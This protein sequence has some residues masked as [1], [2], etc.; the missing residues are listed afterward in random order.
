M[1][2]AERLWSGLW[3]NGVQLVVPGLSIGPSIDKREGIAACGEC[4][5]IHSP[6][7][8]GNSRAIYGISGEIS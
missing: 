6:G 8:A 2:A 3:A 1:G 5:Y 7:R 4:P